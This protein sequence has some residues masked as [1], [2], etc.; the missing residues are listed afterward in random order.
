M[1]RFDLEEPAEKEAAE[2]YQSDF[3][4]TDEELLEQSGEAREEEEEKG[5]GCV[6]KSAERFNREKEFMELYE[7]YMHPEKPLSAF[8]EQCLLDDL[9]EV[10]C[11]L[12]WS[13]TCRKAEK[14]KSAMFGGVDME[15][16]LSVG[17]EY[18]YM[19]LKQHKAEGY[20]I[21][22]PVGYYLKAARR[23]TIDK[24]FR[25]E[26]GRYTV[27]K[28]APDQEEQPDNWEAKGRKKPVE[29]SLDSLQTNSDGEYQG[30]RFAPAS[31]DPFGTMQRV[32]MERDARSNSLML[33][34][35]RELMEYP[36]EPQKALALMYGSVLFQLAKESDS[37]DR[38]AEEAARST[39]VTSASWAHMRMGEQTILELGK[40]SQRV[41]Q[42]TCS[43]SLA[44]GSGFR[45]YMQ[46]QPKGSTYKTW[47]E[48][49]YTNTYTEHET[50]RWIESILKS[51]LK[52]C[53]VRLMAD[54]EQREY[55][56]EL[57]GY[58]SKFRKALA[59]IEK[60]AG[61]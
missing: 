30:D 54:E 12:N 9:F 15:I 8:R 60:E 47:A 24:Y 7:A 28:N 11:K 27:P 42:R 2:Q 36:N 49:V 44:W 37:D 48:V 40:D 41:V 10:L 34:F 19:L 51:T 43:K 32:R 38:Y 17:C 23:K 55:A 29:V 59:K 39:K 61:K 53:A 16:A 25:D 20:Y 50:T 45:T 4:V 5:K 26:F 14:Y 31:W 46:E 35:V 21:E 6:K 33:M 22:K 1:D 57:M 18:A 58:N 13:W 56:V 52:K 3:D